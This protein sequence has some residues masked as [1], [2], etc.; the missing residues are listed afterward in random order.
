VARILAYHITLKNAVNS[1][2]EVCISD[3]LSFILSKK[4]D[5]IKVFYN[6]DYS[7][8][9]IL[10]LLGVNEECC[11][12]ISDETDLVMNGMNGARVTLSEGQRLMPD[13]IRIQYIPKKWFSI[14]RGNEWTGF[15]DMAQYNDGSPL[16]LEQIPE[17]CLNY[18]TEAQ[19]VGEKA[20]S[21]LTSLGLHPK[22]LTSP[23]AIY[24]KE[25]L[26]NADLPCIEDIPEEAAFYSYE[27]CHGPWMEAYKK[28]YFSE[29]FD[30][31]L[32]QAYTWQLSKL[33][34]LRLGIWVHTTGYVE[35]ALYGYCHGIVTINSD[36][37]PIVYSYENTENSFTPKGTWETYL[38][39]QE[40]EFINKWEIGRFNLIDGWFWIPKVVINDTVKPY[41]QLLKPLAEAK[42][43]AKDELTSFIIKKLYSGINGKQ[44]EVRNTG[45]G[46]YFNPV[47]F[48]EVETNTRLA[49]AEFVLANSLKDK[50]LAVTLDGVISSH[51]VQL[52]NS[53]GIGTWKQSA[54]CPAI[55]VSS[56]VQVLRDKKNESVFAL[57]YNW[58]LNE[59]K[60]NPGKD[61]YGLKGNSAVTLKRGLTLNRF[62]DI[63]KIE[64]REI[65]INV[66]DE[67][68]REYKEYPETG[69]DLLSK[70]YNSKP[71]S[72]EDIGQIETLQE[73]VLV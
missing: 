54:Q 50:L 65:T 49:V 2:G 22:S 59:I 57:G 52:D 42:E 37:S 17:D 28:G 36:F 5:T 9:C 10:K 64:E 55:I 73:E 32:K 41:K 14:A 68:K 8:A 6:L 48:C 71:L 3:L 4:E 45:I 61:G 63:G 66:G 29:V 30:Y 7:A 47:Y 67:L 13:W 33:A 31:D 11:Q 16:K 58:L 1:D 53:G 46:D 27:A 38:T 35:K 20:Y 39:K 43:S 60:S 44:L 62:S 56:G 18:A 19:K 51:P 72:V 40:V 34:D 23:I 24:E 12:I 69:G 26:C 15:S 21:V 25:I 70:V